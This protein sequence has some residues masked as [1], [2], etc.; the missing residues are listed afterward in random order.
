MSMF[1]LGHFSQGA[2]VKVALSR[3]VLASGNFPNNVCI[4]DR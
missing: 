4:G 3:L 1:D 2:K